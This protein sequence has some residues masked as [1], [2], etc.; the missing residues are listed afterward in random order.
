MHVLY[1]G[2]IVFVHGTNTATGPV[3]LRERPWA[4]M[5][6][7]GCQKG[8]LGVPCKLQ[9]SSSHVVAQTSY[10]RNDLTSSS[11]VPRTSSGVHGSTSSRRRNKTSLGPVHDVLTTSSRRRIS[12]RYLYTASGQK[13]PHKWAWPGSRDPISKFW[14]PWP[15]PRPL[16][17]RFWS[18]RKA[19]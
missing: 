12:C 16:R 11:D 15:R 6:G 4:W 14:Y 8:G 2:H 19:L 10:R 5:E 9:N 7:I 18:V 1:S 3:G 13:R 17:G